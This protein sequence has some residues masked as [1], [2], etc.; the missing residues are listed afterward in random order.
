MKVKGTRLLRR[1]NWG[2]GGG[3]T[4]FAVTEHSLLTATHA[5]FLLGRGQGL[6]LT[7]TSE[8]APQEGDI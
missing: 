7:G 8:A 6:I 4:I 3:S 5:L 2:G 1:R